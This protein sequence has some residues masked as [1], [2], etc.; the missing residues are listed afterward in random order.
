MGLPKE[1]YPQAR[2]GRTEIIVLSLTFLGPNKTYSKTLIRLDVLRGLLF[3]SPLVYGENK[4]L[5]VEKAASHGS[6]CYVH[7]GQYRRRTWSIDA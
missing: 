3:R 6:G 4:N 2:L 1:W 5:V 7:L